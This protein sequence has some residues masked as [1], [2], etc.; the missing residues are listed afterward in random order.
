MLMGNSLY[1][2][3]DEVTR[4]K[5]E[6][7]GSHCFSYQTKKGRV[8]V[9]RYYLVPANLIDD[10]EQLVAL[11]RESIGVA[12]SSGVSAKRRSA[13]PSAKRRR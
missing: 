12:S 10:P 2:V 5:Y 7:L 9:K 4:P 3:V 11:A 6:K 13:R 1:F 8:D